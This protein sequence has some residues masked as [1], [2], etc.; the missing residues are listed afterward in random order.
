M[1]LKDQE[2]GKKKVWFLIFSF[3]R[4]FFSIVLSPYIPNLFHVPSQLLFFRSFSLL[5]VSRQWRVSLSSVSSTQDPNS[6]LFPHLLLSFHCWVRL[7]MNSLLPLWPWRKWRSLLT[8]CFFCLFDRCHLLL[9][10]V[11]LPSISLFVQFLSLLFSLCHIS[12]F[13]SLLSFFFPSFIPSSSELLLV[14]ISS[15]L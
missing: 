3:F 15:A 11:I 5:S 6:L 4:V 2:W 10:I 14:P 1:L 13:S 8:W 9:I 7:C 12:L